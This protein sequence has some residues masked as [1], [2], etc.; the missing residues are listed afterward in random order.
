MLRLLKGLYLV[1]FRGDL[2]KILQRHLE[3][4]KVYLSDRALHGHVML[5]HSCNKLGN[6]GALTNCMENPEIPER[7]HMQRFIAV[8]IF[9]GKK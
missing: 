9:S 8:E 5:G 2:D 4:M 1:F 6:R 3:M 7:I